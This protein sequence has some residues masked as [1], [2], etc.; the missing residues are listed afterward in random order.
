MGSRTKSNPQSCIHFKCSSVVISFAEVG[1]GEKKSSRLNPFHLG[2]LLPGL[3]VRDVRADVPALMPT[4]SSPEFL[5]KV[6]RRIMNCFYR[7]CNC[8]KSVLKRTGN[9]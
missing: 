4:A 9:Y 5:M 7:I 2:S 6:R 1:L 8:L 3:N